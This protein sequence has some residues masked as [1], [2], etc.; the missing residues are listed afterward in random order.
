[1]NFAR[2]NLRLVNRLINNLDSS[3]ANL[4]TVVTIFYGSK[5]YGRTRNSNRLIAD[6][7]GS[8]VNAKESIGAGCSSNLN[9]N[10]FI[11][12]CKSNRYSSCRRVGSIDANVV[13]IV[14]FTGVRSTV[15]FDS[16]VSIKS[17]FL[18]C[19]GICPTK[20]GNKG[21]NCL[22]CSYGFG[23][24]CATNCLI[25]SFASAFFGGMTESC[26]GFD[27]GVQLAN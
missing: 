17:E 22:A 6:I 24:V 8:T 19:G 13:T 1:M 18:F 14:C 4:L 27:D 12:L 9:G 3:N 23:T 5:N 7:G 11:A 20:L 26:N 15:D 21:C 25:T 10:K 16:Y 2:G